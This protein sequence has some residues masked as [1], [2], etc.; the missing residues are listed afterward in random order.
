DA[1]AMAAPVAQGE[2]GMSASVTMVF[3]IKQ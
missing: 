1:S 3:E 2:V